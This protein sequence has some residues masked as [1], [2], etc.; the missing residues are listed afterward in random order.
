MTEPATRPY[1]VTLTLAARPTVVVVVEAV[2]VADAVTRAPSVGGAP[3]D[4]LGIGWTAETV[5]VD[6]DDGAPVVVWPTTPTLIGPPTTDAPNRADPTPSDA[7]SVTG[8]P[9]APALPPITPPT[10]PT[11]P[12]RRS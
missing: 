12:S 3:D 4:V 2:D 8:T 11:S 6:G 5:T 9:D 10:S 7:P 1:H